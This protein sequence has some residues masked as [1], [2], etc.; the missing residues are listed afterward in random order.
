M[1]ANTDI[2]K[3]WGLFLVVLAVTGLPALAGTY[4][5]GAG[6]EADPYRISTP[7]DMNAIGANDGDWGKHFVM[8][9]DINLA[10]YTGTEF[11]IIG[12]AFPSFTGVFDGND[13]TISN[14]TYNTGSGNNIGLFGC[15]SDPNAV[16]KDLGLIQPDVNVPDGDCLGSMVGSLDYGT[17]SGCF[18]QGSQ[19]SGGGQ[20][21]GLV[22]HNE[23]GTIE[24][25]WM[26]GNISGMMLVG[27]LVGGNWYGKI[28]NSYTVAAATGNA[29]GGL[30]GGNVAGLIASNCHSAGTVKVETHS[31]GGLV[32]SNLSAG[33]IKNCYSTSMVLTNC[34]YVGGLVGGNQ[35]GIENCYATGDVCGDDT[36]GGLAGTNN[37]GTIKTSYSAGSVSGTT[38]V[39]GLVGYDEGGIVSACFWDVN[40]SRQSGSAG[41]NSKTTEQ[42]QTMNTFTDAGWDFV[43]ETTNGER[44]IWDIYEGNYPQLTPQAACYGGGDGSANN[45]YQIWTR[46]DMNEIGTN[47]EDWNKCFILM[48]DVNLASY[49]GTEFNVIGNYSNPFTGVFDGD[50]YTIS[51]FTYTTTD[52]DEIGIFGCIEAA[53]AV[54]KN[55][56]LVNPD[57][58]VGAGDRVGSLIGRLESGTII[59]CGVEGGSVFGD[60]YVGGLV[61]HNA[62]VIENCYSTAA[63]LGNH[64]VG[65]LIG[66]NY[67]FYPPYASVTNCYVSGQVSGT[68]SGYIGGLVGHNEGIVTD[69]DSAAT[70]L[71]DNCDY[72]GGLVGR[73][74]YGGTVSK[75]YATASISGF[76]HYIGGLVGYNAQGIIK[77]CYTDGSSSGDLHILG[78][79]VGLNDGT[80][81]NCYA[82]GQTIGVR[83]IG[84]LVGSNEGTVSKC[85][86]GGTVCGWERVAGLVASNSG[87]VE[88]SYVTAAVSGLQEWPTSGITVGGLVG[89]NSDRIKNCYAAGAVSGYDIVG[90]LVGSDS[91]GSYTSSFWDSTVN[92]SHTGIGNATDPNVIGESTVNM[93]KEST[94]ADAGWDFVGEFINGPNDIWDIC[95]GTN[96][97]KLAW[98]ISLLGDFVCP[99]GVEINDL[100]VF[101]QQWLMEK[102]S[103]DVAAGGGDGIVD[104]LDWAIFAN[105][106]QN[107]SD[108]TMILNFTQQW[109]RFGAYCADIA[110]AG[111][112]DKVDMRDFAVLA[113]N[114]LKGL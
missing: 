101:T 82:N 57:I 104:F 74:S 23:Y 69:S 83:D 87:E 105:T 43:G 112:D 76:G 51:N 80:I 45:P 111:G 18:A 40:T 39:G 47:P 48:A 96:Y 103:A 62:R 61:G 6:T 77:S 30:V 79:L 86:V 41:G 107:T 90:A 21:G 27:G 97:P 68:N 34:D 75:C 46:D 59:G 95:E 19:V 63:V 94:F 66:F 38:K 52:A 99:D 93:Q 100:D 44:D 70:V 114:W 98:Q 55:L 22:G 106:W 15:V 13:H 73:N 50:G 9:N 102:L 71:V 12:R 72:V 85:Y 64:A 28:L 29:V 7:A 31:A 26:T 25:C 67:G 20:V 16:I 8:V 49:T 91:A 108:I 92:S 65:G 35:G 2:F 113:Q 54:I 56:K 24:N 4:S 33:I 58:D 84:G 53:N 60:L 10:D 3:G 32:G 81:S 110:P 42:M 1:N 109:L 88:N 11:N 5:G 89:T 37:N 14:F 36:V 78:G 17:I